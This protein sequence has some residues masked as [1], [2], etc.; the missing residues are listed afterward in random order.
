MLSTIPSWH[1]AECFL[2]SGF[3]A[4]RTIL[5]KTTGALKSM[6]ST[7]DISAALGLPS[8]PST[9][10]DTIAALLWARE[11]LQQH[12]SN[13]YAVN[14]PKGIEELKSINLGNAEQW[15]HIRGRNKNNPVLLWLHG[16]P[17]GA[18]IGAG[19][20]FL[21]PWEDYFTIVMWDQRQTGKSYYPQRDDVEPLTVQQFIDDTEELIQYLLNHLNKEK[22]FILGASW[23]TVLG[24]HMVKQHPEWLHAYIGVGQVVNSLQAE[25]ALYSR[26]LDHAKDHKESKLVNKLKSITAAL[27]ADSPEREKSFADNTVF[28]RRELARLAGEAL[29]HNTSF[30]ETVNIWNFEKLIS[31]HLTFTDLCNDVLGDELAIYRAPYC[32]TKEFL[33]ID[34]PE[35]IGSTFDVPIFFFTGSHDWQTPV[36]L[37]DK[38][39]SEITS[40]YKELVHFE[41]SSHCVINEEPGRFLIGLVN[42]VLPFAKPEV[43]KVNKS[44]SNKN[45]G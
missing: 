34:L 40:P 28:V 16:G 19:D 10:P 6:A 37:S 31:P 22:I 35:D 9:S 23:G 38:W 39:F 33:D 29:M 3:A 5:F 18:V 41:E 8:L 1:S 21:R 30:D 2:P 27:D 11:V 42:K 4:R 43:N 20:A 36:T 26:L 14:D 7:P 44:V 25:K 24:M 32:L 45:N 17:G 12:I 13:T 15:I